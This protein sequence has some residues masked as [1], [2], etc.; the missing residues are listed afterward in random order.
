MRHM[1]RQLDP[2]QTGFQAEKLDGDLRKRIVGQ[3]EAIQ[4]IVSTYQT[5]LCRDVESGATGWQL[6]FS[7]ADRVWK[8]QNGRSCCRKPH[9]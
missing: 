4:Q 3:N 1:G 5:F 7:G 9:R 2:T 8:D 6:S